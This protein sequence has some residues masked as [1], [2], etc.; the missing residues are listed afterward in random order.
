M[1]QNDIFCKPI[2]V[3]DHTIPNGNAIMLT[4]FTRL[5]LMKEAEVLS[6]SLNG[7]LNVYKSF[8]LSSLRAIDFFNEIMSGKKCDE[9]GCKT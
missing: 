5:G 6:K 9:K 1:S 8:M 4:N 7:Y 2:D 3:S